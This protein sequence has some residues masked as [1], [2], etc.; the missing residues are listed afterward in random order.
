MTIWSRE[1]R[2]G[3]GKETGLREREKVNKFRRKKTVY[4]S[5]EW[6]QK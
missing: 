5:N 3:D 4:E 1:K 2:D 6:L